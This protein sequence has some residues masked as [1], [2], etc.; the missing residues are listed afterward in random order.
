MLP[1]IHHCIND[2]EKITSPLN[3]KKRTIRCVINNVIN[4][5]V[6]VLNLCHVKYMAI[7]AVSDATVRM[8]YGS[9]V[10]TLSSN[11]L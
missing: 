5:T 1:V 8:M 2:N 11:T 9:C 3:M 4:M 10:I 6:I 7:N